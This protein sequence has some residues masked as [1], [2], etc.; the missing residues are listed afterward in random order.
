MAFLKVLFKKKFKTVV[1]SQRVTELLLIGVR[2]T[3]S[4]TQ[5]LICGWC[6]HPNTIFNHMNIVISTYVFLK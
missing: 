2:T 1:L 3:E 6:Q 4:Y 5:F